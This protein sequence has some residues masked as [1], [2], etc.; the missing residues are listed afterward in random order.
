M[1]AELIKLSAKQEEQFLRISVSS[2]ICFVHTYLQ[3]SIPK[4]KLRNVTGFAPEFARIF[5]CR[6]TMLSC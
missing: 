4:I 3:D 5:P 6:L 1:I 2:G